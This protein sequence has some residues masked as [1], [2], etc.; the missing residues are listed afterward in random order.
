MLHGNRVENSSWS[1]DRDGKP[2]TTDWLGVSFG[3]LSRVNIK[4]LDK[5]R[6]LSQEG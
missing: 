4:S 6:H 2:A 3:K 1:R 5:I